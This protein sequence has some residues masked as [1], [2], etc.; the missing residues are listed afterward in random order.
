FP[1]GAGWGAGAYALAIARRPMDVEA[2]HMPGRAVGVAW[3]S[4][5]AAKRKLDVSLGGPDLLRPERRVE[6]PVAVAG[7]AP[8][9]EAFVT[10]SA[11]DVGILNLTRYAPP[12][13]FAAFYGQKALAV[14]L[15]DM[16]GKLID[17]MQAVAGDV[18]GGGDQGAQLAAPPPTQPP[19]A[20]FSGLVKL[21]P[22]GHATVAFDLPAFDGSARLTAVA[23]SAGQVG[24][25]TRDVHVRDPVVVSGATPRFLSLDDRA[26]LHLD[27]DDVDGPAGTYALDVSAQGPI[28]IAA[29]DSK[30]RLDLAPGKKASLDVPIGAIG[31][32]PAKLVATLTGPNGLSI[33]R[34][35][36]LGAE[37]GA[38]MVDRRSV[39]RLA[40]GAKLTLSPA[41]L[42]GF[43]PGTAAVSVA[44]SPFGAVDAGDLLARLDR[45]PYGCTEQTVSRALPLLYLADVEKAAHLPHDAAADPR[46]EAAI[47]RVLA[48]QNSAGAFGL[49]DASDQDADPW[50]SAYATD[51]LLR[52]A[53]RGF[54]VPPARTS[55]ALDYLANY[56]ANHRPDDDAK[57]QAIAYSYFDLARAGRPVLA[58]LRYVADAAIKDYRTPLALAQIAAGLAKLG[59]GP[60]A[61]RTFA[62]AVGALQARPDLAATPPNYGSPTRDGAAVLA[63]VGEAALPAAQA[64]G[65]VQKADL[66]F[67]AQRA[68]YPWDSTQDMAW[69]L[70]AAH[71]LAGG[72]DD[73]A[74]R[75]AG[76]PVKGA[77]ALRYVASGLAGGPVTIVNEGKADAL[78]STSVSGR[79]LAPEPAETRDLSVERTWRDLAGK[80]VDPAKLKQNDRVVVTLTVHEKTA[81]PGRLMLVDRLPGGLEIE[82][83]RLVD[84]ATADSFSWLPQGVAAT[85]VEYRDDRLLAAFSGGEGGDAGYSVSYVARATTPG[86]YVA[87]A[88]TVE[89]M[90]RPDRFGRTAAARVVVSKP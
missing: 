18:R 44:A 64:G 70:L 36:P 86:T 75:V 33:A 83:P 46:I 45:Y 4:V 21:D 35:F 66:A 71:A 73:M 2:K 59:D 48:R 58:D 34:T 5:D 31:V 11:V 81:R 76:A 57:A 78:V 55:Q 8:G 56:A 74:F 17:G 25:A 9:A 23:W 85:H 39:V 38:P 63:L 84:G 54:D 26:R 49:W 22:L 67:A 80:P 28:A 68:A 41:L 1:V 7:L 77:L 43:V 52:A 65:L 87:P 88:A 79:P 30:R 60:R 47:E 61:E 89:D 15:R 3:F 24:V 90:Y 50:L 10:V 27:L 82:N 53:A 32:G 6:I 51:F 62:R 69:T 16:Y 29:A 40:P 37:P 12:D 13:P 19:L 20:L 14:D 42:A 72:A